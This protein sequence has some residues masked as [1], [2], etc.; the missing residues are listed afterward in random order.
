MGQGRAG[1]SWRRWAGVPYEVAAR[2]R[3]WLYR[4]GW[5]TRTR[6]P[7]PVVSVGNLTVG[8][9]GKTPVVIHLVEQLTGQGKRVAVLSR[10]YRRR[11]SAAQLLVSDGRRLLASAE[12][13]GDE[14]Y[15]IASRCPGAIVAVGADRVALGTWV[16]QQAPVDCFVLDDGFQH[17]RLHRDVDLLLV[18]ASDPEGIQAALPFGRLREPITAARR[19]D[20]ILIT[21]AGSAVEA[22]PVW[23]CLTQACGPLPAPVLV[24]FRAD[25]FQRIG[26]NETKTADAL[27]DAPALLFSGVGNSG[28]FHALAKALGIVVRETLDFRDHAH[29]TAEIVE[30]IR[31][32]TKACGAEL[33]VTTE[34]D[35][36]KVVPFL[37]PDDVWWAVRLQTEIVVGRERLTQL[38]RLKLAVVMQE[39]RA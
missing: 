10:G 12:E 9:T 32:R 21:R 25:S 20:A 17:L 7:R 14:P 8:G 29:Y 39:G 1:S 23:R 16:L 33:A 15:L 22:E 30:R 36:G 38:L 2:F 34:K 4:R 11:S 35:A 19:A 37:S 28:S 3:A 18:D 24:Q 27:K 26:G 13:A 5:P 6:L 31:Q